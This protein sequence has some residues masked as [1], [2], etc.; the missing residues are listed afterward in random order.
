VGNPDEVSL[1]RKSRERLQT[2]LMA[3]RDADTQWE[4]M[5]YVERFFTIQTELRQYFS[6]IEREIAEKLRE[7]RLVEESE[8][9]TSEPLHRAT[10]LSKRRERN[11][12][13]GA[14]GKGEPGLRTF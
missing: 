9:A 5:L 3:V 6:L 13:G 10:D 4:L 14:G 8:R 12:Q 2:L 7:F 1:G 11:H